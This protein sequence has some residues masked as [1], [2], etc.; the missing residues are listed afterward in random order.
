MAVIL[1]AGNGSRIKNISGALPKPLIEVNGR[2]LLEH[3]IRDSQAAG[4]ERF[5]IVLGYRAEAIEQWLWTRSFRGAQ[6]EVV[7]TDYLKANGISTLQA[8]NLV[9]DRFLLLMSDHLF[10]PQT[11]ADLLEERVEG[12]S[13][14][15]AVDR[16][17]EAVFDMDDATKVSTIGTYI[18]DIG[19]QLSRFDAVDTGMFVCS[20]SLFTALDASVVDG[21]CSLSDGMRSLAA[22]RKLRAFDIGDARWQDVDTPEALEHARVVFDERFV[23]NTFE[24]QFVNV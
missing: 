6:I 4:I 3:V 5:V 18:T 23:R 13:T 16:K 14:I 7:K 22:K 9:K 15:L 21:N 11:A 8:R 1:A 17:L 20:Q 24:G 19:K 2:P 12:E 10:D